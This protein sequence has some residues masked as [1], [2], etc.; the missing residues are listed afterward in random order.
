M[1]FITFI[2][3]RNTVLL[4]Q[5]FTIKPNDTHYLF[6]L[7]YVNDIIIVENKAYRI[8]IPGK[9]ETFLFYPLTN[10]YPDLRIS[11]FNVEFITI[12]G[13]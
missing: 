13:E 8:Q 9:S 1:S 6:S 10:S 4:D 5:T 12:D 3:L 11:T 2:D 7:F